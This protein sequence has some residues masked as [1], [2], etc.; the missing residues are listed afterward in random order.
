MSAYNELP[1][2]FKSYWIQ[3]KIYELYYFTNVVKKFEKNGNKIHIYDLDFVNMQ[4][5][6]AGKESNYRFSLNY[7]IS[8]HNYELINN[9]T[10]Y[11]RYTNYKDVLVDLWNINKN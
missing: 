3:S 1:D 8:T 7:N 5:I 2:E 6:K 9:K 11:K 4:R 10:I